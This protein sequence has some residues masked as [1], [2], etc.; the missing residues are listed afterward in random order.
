MDKRL[1]L[2]ARAGL[3]GSLL[4]FVGDML[5]YFTTEPLIDVEKDLLIFMGN[6]P[7]ARLFAGGIV[8]PFAMALYLVGF[9]HLYLR[10]KDPYKEWGRWTFVLLGMGILCSGA[11]HAFFPAFGIVSSEGQAQLIEPLLSY[12]SW[13]GGIGFAL[14]GLG[15]SLYAYLILRQHT[16]FPRWVVLFTPIVTVW[17]GAIWSVLPT[18]LPVI[19]GGG[20]FNIIFSL[21]YLI[22]LVTMRG[23][24]RTTSVKKTE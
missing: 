9:Y 23:Q 15:W 11:Y 10:T 22:A 14:L 24:T 17:L 16:D 5:L 3:L 7:T 13:L 6:V 21:F 1:Y 19:I 12:L 18:P 20:W 4:M 8:A 2:T